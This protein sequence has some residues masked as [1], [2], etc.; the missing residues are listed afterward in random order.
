M[1]GARYE[2]TGRPEDAWLQAVLPAQV[3][4]I[5]RDFGDGSIRWL[6]GTFTRS[7]NPR[8]SQCRRSE[9]SM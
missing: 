9:R 3:V 5:V 2:K 1:V 7:S 6:S 8:D 4:A